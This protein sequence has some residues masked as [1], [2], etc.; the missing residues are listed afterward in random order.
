LKKQEILSN[1]LAF[2]VKHHYG[3]FD[4]AGHAYILHPLKVMYLMKTDDEELM[5]IAVLHDVVEDC[6]PNDHE[7]GFAALHAI[8]MT[9]R[10][11]TAVRLLTRKKE[12][13][14]DEYIDGI[15][16]N[17]DAMR[18]KKIDLRHNMDLRRLKGVTDKDMKRIE[19]YVKTYHKIDTALKAVDIL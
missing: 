3:Q 2:A 15:M 6:F 13:P 11:I 10:I 4:K 19:K 1:A 9:P 14:Y 5:A 17:I 7:A 12:I 8:G 18:A 16:G